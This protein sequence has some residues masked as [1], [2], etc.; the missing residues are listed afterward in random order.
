M[1]HRLVS[2]LAVPTAIAAGVVVAFDARA[3]VG[4]GRGAALGVGIAV[5]TIAASLS[6]FLLPWDQLALSAVEAGSHVRGYR[7][8]FE[9]AVRF[10]IS[11]GVELGPD[12]G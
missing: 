9:S 7:V 1:T 8:L 5:T 10:V 12:T 11:G 2:W 3:N 4:R 6:G